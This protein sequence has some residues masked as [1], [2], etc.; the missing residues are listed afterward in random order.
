M[1]HKAQNVAWVCFE[2]TVSYIHVEHTPENAL[3]FLVKINALGCLKNSLRIS[4]I[5]T[6]VV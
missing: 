6:R 4:L 1:Y 2:R 3:G 5:G